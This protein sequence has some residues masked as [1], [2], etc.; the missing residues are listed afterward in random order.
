MSGDGAHLFTEARHLTGGHCQ[1]GLRGHIPAG[2]SRTACRQNQITA[3]DIHEFTQRFLD[4]ELLIGNQ[5]LVNFQRID[6]G[7][8]TPGFKRRDAFVVVDASAGAVRNGDQAQ[9]QFVFSATGWLHKKLNSKF[10]R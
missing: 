8:F 10:R 9:N 7:L 4:G 6:H 1:R 5:T 3:D 2:R